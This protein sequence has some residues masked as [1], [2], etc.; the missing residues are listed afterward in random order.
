MAL[1]TLESLR[2]I[3]REQDRRGR[4]KGT[5]CVPIGSAGGRTRYVWLVDTG[6]AVDVTLLGNR[7]GRV[8]DAGTRVWTCGYYTPTTRDALAWLTGLYVTMHV[9]RT[10]DY[11]PTATIGAGHA[12]RE[13]MYLTEH[14]ESFAL[15]TISS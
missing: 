8:D 9:A 1:R 7:V 14:P 13:G 12:L 4:Q 10:K 5:A 6:D 15:V 2:A 11:P 3:I